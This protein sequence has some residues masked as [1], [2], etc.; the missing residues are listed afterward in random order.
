MNVM[1]NCAVR[2][3]PRTKLRPAQ[4]TGE[5][6]KLNR[7]W[8]GL[9]LD[10][11]ADTSNV[12]R[13]AEVAGINPA[14]A[15]RVR[16][17]EPGFA[18]KWHAALLEGYENLELETLQRL[19]DGTPKEDEG[20]KFDITHAIRLL[21]LHR[22]TVARHRVGQGHIDEISVIASINA[23]FAARRAREKEAAALFGKEA[24]K[25]PVGPLP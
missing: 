13:S 2:R 21:V 24:R 6:E 19:R 23:K 12:T 10:T 1:A 20:P 18:R 14:R 5:K 7:H 3:K 25:P 8:R 17:A 9:F 22:E 4:K 16:R 15:Y 11:L